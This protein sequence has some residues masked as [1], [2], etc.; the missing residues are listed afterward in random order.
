MIT[1]YV[2]QNKNMKRLRDTDYATELARGEYGD[3]RIERLRIKKTKEE[4]IR[5]SWWPEGKMAMRP[6]D[7]PETELIELLRKG[8][9]NR[10][11]GDHFIIELRTL[12]ADLRNS[13]VELDSNNG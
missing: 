6:L 12:I 11:S 9:E 13:K 2:L 4:G 3:A 5:F 7:L 1:L 8:I 10:G